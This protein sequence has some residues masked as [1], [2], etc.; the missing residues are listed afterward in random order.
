MRRSSDTAAIRGLTFAVVLFVL[1]GCSQY[2]DRRDTISL[3]GGDALAADKVTMMVDPWPRW[4]GERN[5]AFNGA[6]MQS[7]VE[8][9]RTH[10]VI[11]PQGTGT[12]AAFQAPSQNSSP[13]TAKPV[14]PTITQEN[15]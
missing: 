13:D 7:A 11:P 9:Y 10:R 15:Q 12:S 2:L 1:G 5:I 8:R 6:R 3:N 4:A 14:G